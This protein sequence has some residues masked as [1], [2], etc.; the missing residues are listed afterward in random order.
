MRR[1][2]R[3]ERLVAVQRLGFTAIDVYIP[4]NQHERHDGGWGFTGEKDVPPQTVI[5]GID[6]L[7]DFGLLIAD[8]PREVGTRGQRVRYRVN[9][10]AVTEMYLRLG[11][12]IGEI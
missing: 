7:L 5:T 1:G 9:D 6:E 10:Q 8:P 4:W 12:A 11:L 2:Q 3:R